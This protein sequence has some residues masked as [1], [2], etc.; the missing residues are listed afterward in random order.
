MKVE[1][2][3]ARVLAEAVAAP[4]DLRQSIQVATLKK[5]LDSQKQEAAEMRKLMEPKGRV[6]DILV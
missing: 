5:A 6:I 4:N 2:S 1:N 3:A